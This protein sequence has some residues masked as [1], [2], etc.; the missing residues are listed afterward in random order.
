MSVVVWDGHTIAAD[1]MAVSSG[2][3]RE[4][5]KLHLLQDTTNT[6]I[7]AAFTG[8]FEHG[9]VL[10]QWYLEE[11]SADTYPAFQKTDNWTRMIIVQKD[12]TDITVRTYE[13][14]HIPTVFPGATKMAWGAGRDFAMGAMMAGAT[15]IKAVGITNGLSD[16]CGFGFSHIGFDAW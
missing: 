15:A 13:Q 1:C 3:K 5:K 10:L 2:M 14:T 11:R 6:K 8:T 9:A 7:A 12:G 16:S 4:C